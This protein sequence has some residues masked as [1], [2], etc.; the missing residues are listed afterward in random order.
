MKSVLTSYSE[1]LNLP[2]FKKYYSML[3]EWNEKINLTAI[4]NEDEVYVKH[5]LDSIIGEKFFPQNASVIDVGAGAGF[6]SLPLKIARAD[7]SVVMLDSLNKRINFLNEV[8]KEL[9]L[10]KIKSVHGRAEDFANNVEYREKFDCATA[11][12]VAKLST[13]AEYCLPFVKIGGTF[14]AYKSNEIDHEIEE[15][16]GAISILGGKIEKVEKIKLSE[17]VVRTFIIIKKIKQ[18]SKKYP[19]GSN[20]PKLLPLK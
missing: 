16:K 20:K 14:V 1:L 15:S 6:P 9:D 5:F 18:T 11:R 10:K 12:A 4:T 17:D 3:V 8:V 2:E 7:L 13:L 19:R